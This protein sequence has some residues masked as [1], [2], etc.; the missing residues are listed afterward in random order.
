MISYKKALYKQRKI[1]FLQ[2]SVNHHLGIVSKNAL[3][4][5]LHQGGDSS[6]T[7]SSEMSLF[8]LNEKLEKYHVKLPLGKELIQQNMESIQRK[9]RNHKITFYV[10]D[11]FTFCN[12]V[13]TVLAPV[14]F[15]IVLSLLRVILS[16]QK[17]GCLISS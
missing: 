16:I 7:F 1:I 11:F 12:N 5:I 6:L 10:D 17:L 3:P 15:S 9:Q 13:T 2:R 14:T 4:A 8:H